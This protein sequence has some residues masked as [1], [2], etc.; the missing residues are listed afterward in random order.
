MILYIFNIYSKGKAR[1]QLEMLQTKLVLFARYT[2]LSFCPSYTA[3]K[4]FCV[5]PQ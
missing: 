4:Y 2:K 5:Q 3:F 1:A